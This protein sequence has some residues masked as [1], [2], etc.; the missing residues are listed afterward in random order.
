MADPNKAWTPEDKKK[1]QQGAG[2]DEPGTDYN[3]AIKG[4][5]GLSDAD[6]KKRLAD[7]MAKSGN[8]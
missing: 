6:P 1:F 2:T 5:L 7:T 4:F 3:A 8:Y